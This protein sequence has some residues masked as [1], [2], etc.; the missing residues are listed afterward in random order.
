MAV[1]EFGEG[2]EKGLHS[3]LCHQGIVGSNWYRVEFQEIP[4][5]RV[6]SLTEE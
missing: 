6:S 2:L 4:A 3:V 5:L 1:T